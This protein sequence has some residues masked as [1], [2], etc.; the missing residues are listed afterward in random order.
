MHSSSVDVILFV[1]PEPVCVLERSLYYYCRHVELEYWRPTVIV[2]E[3]LF[4]HLARVGKLIHVSTNLLTYLQIV[5]A[6]GVGALY[7]GLEPSLVGTACSQVRSSIPV[8]FT[9]VCEAMNPLTAVSVLL[10]SSQDPFSSQD[11]SHCLDLCLQPGR[12][13][14][15]SGPTREASKGPTA[16]L[17]CSP[18]FR[19]IVTVQSLFHECGALFS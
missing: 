16:M 6:E 17:Q 19:R 9:S 1:W 15:V 3:A 18:C 11:T 10:L 7:R 14:A 2:L 5:R 13:K 12:V 4:L 8:S